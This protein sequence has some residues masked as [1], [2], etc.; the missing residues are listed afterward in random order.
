MNDMMNI[1]GLNTY[2]QRKFGKLFLDGK[3]ILCVSLDR[4]CTFEG[5]GEDDIV[6]TDTQMADLMKQAY[7]QE[8]R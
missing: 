3:E 1:V 2:I 7:K 5:R 8:S 6:L 4:T